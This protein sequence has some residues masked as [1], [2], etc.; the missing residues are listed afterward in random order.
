MLTEWEIWAVADA[1]LKLHGE[2]AP[3]FVAERIGVLAAQ[4]DAEG[5]AAWRAIARRMTALS[6]PPPASLHA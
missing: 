3:L 2:K 5:V 6:E 1:T 4:G